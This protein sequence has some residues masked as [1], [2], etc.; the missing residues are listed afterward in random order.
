MEEKT[1]GISEDWLAVWIGLFIFVVSLGAF[2]GTDVL[3]W[4]VTTG[5]WTDITKALKP[6]SA[7]WLGGFGSLVLTYVVLLVVMTVGAAALKADIKK[8]A[9]G[10]TV[11]FWISYVCWIL[12]SYAN[13][14]V[15]TA[16]DMKKFG[17]TWSL[18]LTAEAGF[19][20]ALLVGLF[21]GNFVPSLGNWIK[22]AVRPELYIKTAIVILGGSLGLMAAEK[23]G[24]ATAVM[25]RGLCAIVEA[26]LIYWALVYFIARKYFKFSR[27]WA[28]PLA[29]GI[30]ICGVSAAIATGGAIKARPVVPIMVSSLVVIFAVVEL[31]ILPFFAETFLYKEPMVAGA[32]MGLA[33]KTD[34]AAVAAGAVTEGLILGRNAAEGIMYQPEW[35]KNAAAVVKVFIDVFIGVWAFVL[36]IIWCSFIECKPGERVRPGQIWD[37]FPKFVIGY[38]VTFLIILLVCL[39]ASKTATAM[40]KQTGPLAKQITAGEVQLAALSK[41]VADEEA[42]LAATKPKDKKAIAALKS[43]IGNDKAAVAS[44][45]DKLAKDK[46]QLAPLYDQLK[47]PMATMG[48]AKAATGEANVFRGIFFVMTFFTIGLVSNFKKLWE[49]GIGKLAAVYVISLFGFIIWIGLIISWIFF[50][51]VKPPLVG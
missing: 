20:I 4:G 18:K 14:A 31:V 39:P 51:G 45:A 26:Y 13:I 43:Q 3:K 40:N 7:T 46:A 15:T 6:I 48:A 36:A 33:V 17:I 9:I 44:L 28:A 29:S 34:G 24:L 25:F 21:F 5:V 1:K 16:P 35:I 30:S 49:E 37:R 10:F 12:G 8:F 41:Q 22:E 32:W 23:L 19:I 11:V 2:V 27:E 47:A 50:H 38:I 42:K